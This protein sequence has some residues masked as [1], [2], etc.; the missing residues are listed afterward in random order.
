MGYT[1]KL[2]IHARKREWQ[3]LGVYV[4]E[5]SEASRSGVNAKTLRGFAVAK[6]CPVPFVLGSLGRTPT[7]VDRRTHSTGVDIPEFP[8]QCIRKVHHRS[9]RSCSLEPHIVANEGFSYEP[10]PAF[11]FDLPV[12]SDSPHQ[13]MT[14]ILHCVLPSF[15]FWPTINLRRRS[16]PQPFVRSH[17]V[18]GSQPSIRSPLLRSSIARHRMCRFGLEHPM[19][20]FVCAV[21]LGVPRRNK[22]H[23]D[24]QCHPPGAQARKP[25]RTRGSKGT[26]IVHTDHLRIAVSPKEPE[27]FSTD[28]PPTLV[29]QQAN[30]QQ[31]ATEEISHCQRFYTATVLGTKPTLE[32]DCPHLVGPSRYGQFGPLQARATPSPPPAFPT[33]QAHTFEPIADRPNTRYL[34][35]WM[36]LA[37]ARHQ[38]ATAPTGMAATQSTNPLQPFGCHLPR[39]SPRLARSV[40]QTSKPVPLEAPDPF[41]ACSAAPSKLS[42]QFAELALGLARQ[43]HKLQPSHYA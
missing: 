38:L 6:G 12:A 5:A 8:D 7:H 20:L 35:P 17:L 31:I 29:L 13:P 18:V 30:A 43:F 39:T 1:L 21:L 25:C 11:P 36:S 41:V 27:E 34:L 19:H 28:R 37:Q 3:R 32:I 16:L 10:L 23:S 2:D 9:A 22:F 4:A 15:S 24:S 40:L 33:I 26:A 42:A 14:R